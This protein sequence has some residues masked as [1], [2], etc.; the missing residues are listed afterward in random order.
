MLT[1]GKYVEKILGTSIQVPFVT[2][3]KQ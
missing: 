2:V 3:C 1:W